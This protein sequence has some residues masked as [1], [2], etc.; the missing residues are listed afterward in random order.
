[1]KVQTLKKVLKSSY[2]RKKENIDGYEKNKQLSGKRAQVYYDPSTKKAIVAHRGSQGVRDWIKTNTAMAVGYE[3]GKRFQHAKKIQNK[4]EKMYGA[5]NVTTV[6]HSLGGRIAE[7]VGQKSSRVITYNKA[8]TPRSLLQPTS[9]HQTDIRT[10]QDVV[11]SLGKFQ[12]KKGEN[13]EINSSSNPV[14]AHGIQ[15]LSRLKNTSV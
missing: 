5:E 9:F 3:G 10:K 11:S 6:G 2:S 1:M 8:V 13:L 15:F 4:A 7:K 12:K 14:K